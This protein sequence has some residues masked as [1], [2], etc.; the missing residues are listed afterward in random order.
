MEGNH[1][2]S[3][4]GCTCNAPSL[5]RPIHEYSHAIGQ[6]I[7]AG[8]VYRGC[9]MPDWTGT[10]FFADYHTGRIFSLRYDGMTVSD[11]T[12]RT[13]QLDP[14]GTQPITTVRQ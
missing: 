12:E 8:Y 9:A 1:C 7:T 11:V 6:S 10:F 14:P 13:M 2:T 4:T 5:V 3:M